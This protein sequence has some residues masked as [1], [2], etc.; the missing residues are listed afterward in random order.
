MITRNLVAPTI[1]H[2]EL[3]TINSFIEDKIMVVLLLADKCRMTF[4]MDTDDYSD[5]ATTPLKDTPTYQ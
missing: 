1:N 2:S 4:E 5:K 3:D